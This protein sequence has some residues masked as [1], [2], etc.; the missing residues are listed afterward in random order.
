[1]ISGSMP[2]DWLTVLG[3]CWQHCV[4]S[5]AFASSTVGVPLHWWRKCRER[6]ECISL[7][8]RE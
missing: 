8:T 6:A 4:C 1:M 5:T 7:Y 2:E 3:N